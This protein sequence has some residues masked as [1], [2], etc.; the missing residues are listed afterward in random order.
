MIEQERTEINRIIW[1]A[2]N[3]AQNAGMKFLIQYESG[4]ITKSPEID[5]W[6]NETKKEFKVLQDT[7]KRYE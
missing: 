2:L 5:A 1:T 4:L 3:N 6:Y 7:K